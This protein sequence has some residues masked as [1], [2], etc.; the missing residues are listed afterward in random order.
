MD[1]MRNNI[2]QQM[3]FIIY[4]LTPSGIRRPPEN[5][6]RRTAGSSKMNGRF[7]SRR[8]NSW[9]AMLRKKMDG[10]DIGSAHFRRPSSLYFGTV[11]LERLPSTLDSAGIPDKGVVRAFLDRGAKILKCKKLTKCHLF[12]PIMSQGVSGPLLHKHVHSQGPLSGHK[13]PLRRGHKWP[14]R[15]GPSGTS[16]K[17]LSTLG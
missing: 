17:K 6:G 4:K 11:Q 9:K 7:R 10:S 1:F 3:N 13:W 16:I 15:A 2:I 12:D 8:P 14:I 5:R